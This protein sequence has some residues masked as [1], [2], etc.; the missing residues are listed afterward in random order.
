MGRVTAF[1][2]DEDRGPPTPLR[3]WVVERTGWLLHHHRPARDYETRPHRSEATIH[4]AMID[5]MSRRPTR[6]SAHNRRD[7]WD[8]TRLRGPLLLG[9]GALV[10]S[11]LVRCARHDHDLYV[12]LVNDSPRVRGTQ[13][14]AVD[15]MRGQNLQISG[16]TTE[17]MSG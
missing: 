3:R 9:V 7:I 2:R 14:L 13:D 16:D 1:E 5:L 10:G 12:V 4:L 15:A 8:R 11:G 6:E 17:E